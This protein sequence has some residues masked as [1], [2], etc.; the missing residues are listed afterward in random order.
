LYINT[1]SPMLGLPGTSVTI[2]GSSFGASQGTSTVTFNGIL[3]TPTSWGDSSITVPVPSGA[4]TGSVVVT[5]GGIASNGIVFSISPQINSLSPQTGLI[6]TSITISGARFGS[7][8]GTSTVTFNDTAATPTSWSD[9]SIAV[10][11]PS[12]ATTGPVVVTV[13]GIPS[14]GVTFTVLQIT[15]TYPTPGM[16]LNQPSTVVYG[17][18][19]A[20][21]GDFTVVVNGHYAMI[22]GQDFAINN[23]SLAS[24]QNTISVTLTDQ[25]GESA[26][27][28]VTVQSNNQNA[29]V[30][31][32]SGLEQSLA[33]MTSILTLGAQLP[34]ST[35]TQTSLVVGTADLGLVNFPNQV[36]MPTP[37]IYIVTVTVNTSNFISYQDKF[38]F[39]VL[40]PAATE[41]LLKSTWNNMQTA[42]LGGD[43][44]GALTYFSKRIQSQYQSIFTDLQSVLPQTF[45]SIENIVL[46][47]VTNDTAEMTALRTEGG[48][49]ISYP[50]IFNLDETG[51]WKINSF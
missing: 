2:T 45:A 8:Q 17:T 13:G 42:L 28:S 5:V 34:T 22:N 11:V 18:L 32:S 35:I 4:T 51:T 47:N 44:S 16:V 6:G 49:L 29:Y 36:T 38:A 43:L 26:T 33:P 3:A 19:P 48:Q 40:D 37:G 25:A 24:G 21:V 39:N 15:I 23:V 27:G 50:I 41:I 14:S 30:Q 7:S 20:V 46:L 1:I 12:G 9:T 31:L 10:P